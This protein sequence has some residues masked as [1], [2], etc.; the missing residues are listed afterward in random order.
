V[1]SI[2]CSSE[3]NTFSCVQFPVVCR[4]LLSA[5]NFC[6]GE[7]TAFQPTMDPSSLPHM[8]QNTHLEW[9]LTSEHTYVLPPPLDD[10]L[11]KPPGLLKRK[12]AM[13][14]S[15][16]VPAFSS[17][18]NDSPKRRRIEDSDDVHPEQ[19]VS[20]F[21]SEA[22]LA[23]NSTN[24]FS[25]PTSRVLSGPKRSSSPTRETAVILMSALPSVLTESLDGL[26]EDPP[27]YVQRLRDRLSIGMYFSF[28]SQG[29]RVCA[30]G[31]KQYG[32]NL[33]LLSMLLQRTPTWV[34]KQ[35]DPLTL[36]VPTSAPARSY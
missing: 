30:F 17:N 18:R 24:T 6:T 31:L 26:E 8:P 2:E 16:N 13:S 10:E 21:G 33:R 15:G 22:S 29:L 1:L 36:I 5:C 27:E 11:S 32:L 34:T 20:Q 3:S 35:L 14:F 19:S 9:W 12:R 23:L 25:P 4:V 7:N 28:V